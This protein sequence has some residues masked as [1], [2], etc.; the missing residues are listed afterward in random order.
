MGEEGD[1][2]RRSILDEVMVARVKAGQHARALD[3]GCGEGRFCRKLAEL[4]IATIGIDPTRALLD[5]AYR[6]DQQGDYRIGVGERLPFANEYFD[7]VISYLSLIDIENFVGAI[8]EMNRVLARGGK[9]LVANLTSFSTARADGGW[10]HNEFGRLSYFAID[11]Y[12]TERSAWENWRGIEV[13][14]WHRPL[15]AYMQAF[16]V[17]GLALTFFD[18]PATSD[19]T[20][21]R[22]AMYR[23]VPWYV[24]MEWVKP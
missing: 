15:C 10:H 22:A 2:G 12:L 8:S 13:K 3:V 18:E 21:P 4:G 14:N 16:L 23:R 24:V 6:K 20:S 17:H 1:W 19:D 9:L 7:L 5:E 11:D